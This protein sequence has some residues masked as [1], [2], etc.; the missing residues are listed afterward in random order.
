MPGNGVG[1][2]ANAWARPLL[3]ALLLGYCYKLAQPHLLRN[4]QP[5]CTVHTHHAYNT[6]G[7]LAATHPKL[8]HLL[9]V[10]MHTHEMISSQCTCT[11]TVTVIATC[12]TAAAP[13]CCRLH[14]ER[15]RWLTRPQPPHLLHGTPPHQIDS[16]CGP[17]SHS[18]HQLTTGTPLYITT[19]GTVGTSTPTCSSGAWGC[20]EGWQCTC[21]AVKP[22]RHCCTEVE[23]QNSWA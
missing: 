6:C 19:R 10:T 23:A 20:G 3:P 4:V 16:T 12:A 11:P 9:R 18:N 17:D 1:C 5:P 8:A 22:Q 13:A 14:V 15:M 21:C 2:H 7:T